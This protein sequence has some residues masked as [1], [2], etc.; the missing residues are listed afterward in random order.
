MSQ[1]FLRFVLLAF[2]MNALLA[3]REK[4]AAPPAPSPRVVPAACVAP[5]P[6]PAVANVITNSAAPPTAPAH[7]ILVSIDGGRPDIVQQ[8]RMPT[9]HAMARE[10]A[11]TWSARSIVPPLTL[12]AHTSMLTGL[13]PEEHGVYW[14]QWMPAFG[15][16]RFPTV[17][18]LARAAGFSTAMFSAKDKLA[19][20]FPTGSVDHISYPVPDPR[21]WMGTNHFLSATTVATQAVTYFAQQKPR[22]MF[23]HFP[24]ADLCDGA[25]E[26]ASDGFFDGHNTPPWDTWVGYF[27]DGVDPVRGLL[28]L[29]ERRGVD[30]AR[31]IEQHE[32]RVVAHVHLAAPCDPVAPRGQRRHLVDPRFRG[33]PLHRPRPRYASVAKL[34]PRVFFVGGPLEPATDQSHRCPSGGSVPATR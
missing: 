11:V 14:N 34:S 5:G 12:P 26:L 24:D 31:R 2:T 30:H 22:L 7:L 25:A 8:A 16:L 1:I 27:R 18:A 33:A 21:D 32:I 3:C 29:L 28:R 19:Y 9:L 13:A 23:V 15:T 17:L 20:L 4:T 6:P 10:G